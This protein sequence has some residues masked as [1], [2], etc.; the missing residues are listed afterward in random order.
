LSLKIQKC[1]LDDLPVLCE[2]SRATYDDTFRHLNTPETMT[3]YLDA[4]FAPEKIKAELLSEGSAFYFLYAED[5]LAG[6]LKLNIGKAQTD[7]HDLQSLEVERIYVRREFQGLGL[8]R[9]LLE[10]AAAEA[11]SL[12]KSY[13]WLGVWE[14]NENAIAFYKKHGF[15]IIGNHGFIMGDEVQN[16]FVMRKDL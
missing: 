3:A 16:D 7:I 13:L 8:G 15:H 1:V 14:K 2:L 10:K 4:A 11:K 12:G 6:Y 5:A 9:I